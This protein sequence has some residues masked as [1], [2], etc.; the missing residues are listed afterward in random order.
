M[1]TEG[2]CTKSPDGNHMRMDGVCHYCGHD[3]GSGGK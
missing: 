2:E 1:D 3:D